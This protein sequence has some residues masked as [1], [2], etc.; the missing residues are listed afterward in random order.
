[1]NNYVMVGAG[2][3]GTH[4]LAPLITYLNSHHADGDW[5]LHV[6]D[7]DIVEAKNLERQLFRPADVTANKAEA[8]VE[9]CANT[10]VRAIPQYLSEENLP[11]ML[12][13]GDTVLICADNFTVRKRIEDH[14]KALDDV[15][16]INGG[17]EKYSGS[18]QLWVRAAGEDVTP[19]IGYLHPEIAL[20]KGE[21]RAAMTCAQAAALPGGEQTIIANLQSATWMLTALWRA[22]T[23]AFLHSVDQEPSPLTWTEL[24]FDALLGTVDHI[25]Q[26]MSAHWRTA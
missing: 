18:I 14:C 6:M 25:D 5:M 17:N 24:Q 1:M 20:R 23:L 13:N 22:H 11:R 15:I 3:T 19:R 7:G 2:G 26:R 10:H 16:V 9:A 21:D 12:Q 4:L 8:A